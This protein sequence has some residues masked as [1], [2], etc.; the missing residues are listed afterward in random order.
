MNF[1]KKGN[2]NLRSETSIAQPMQKKTSNIL[3]DILSEL[4][5]EHEK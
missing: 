1:E 5:T 3:S 4:T 2:L